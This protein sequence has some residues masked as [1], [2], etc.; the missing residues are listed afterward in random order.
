M[1]HTMQRSP[2]SQLR[3]AGR[4]FAVLL[5]S[6]RDAWSYVARILCGAP[7]SVKKA[8]DIKVHRCGT[9]DES[10]DGN[11]QGKIPIGIPV[12]KSVGQERVW[13]GLSYSPDVGRSKSRRSL[14]VAKTLW[15]NAI[16]RLTR[17]SEWP[18]VL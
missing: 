18:S 2:G 16:K 17:P 6:P 11:S 3:N 5:S 4:P 10:S 9:F 7:S 1:R 14:Q 15:G 13:D 8:G 12:I